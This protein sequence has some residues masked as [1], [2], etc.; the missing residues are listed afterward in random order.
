VE[1]EPVKARWL[2][3]LHTSDLRALE[4]GRDGFTSPMRG[5]GR[6]AE[7]AADYVVCFDDG[8]EVRLPVRRR[9]QIGAFQRGWGENCF[10]AVAHHKPY[11]MRASHEQVNPNWGWSQTRN[12]AADG[13][14]WVNW[15]W[16]WENGYPDKAIT[17]L[18]F[19]PVSGLVVVS[20]ITAG[21][22]AALPLRWEPRRK[23]LLILPEGID[24]Q[25][26][27]DE[28]GVLQQIQLDL[29]QVIS[30]T[31]RLVYPNEAWQDSYNNQLP[32]IT[33]GE[34]IIEYTAHPEACFHLPDGI[35][36]P[37][38]KVEGG[39]EEVPVQP[40]LPATQSVRLR[41][42]ERGSGKPVAVKLHLHG[43]K[44]EY[45]APIDRHRILNPAW[46]ED[47]SVDF[48]HL[49]WSKVD[50]VHACTYIAGETALSC[51]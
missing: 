33:A 28:E 20:A 24:F 1:I 21:D 34:V 10:E 16:A 27:L 25:P 2:V 23:A 14:E 17:G 22:V 13:G 31:P 6:L 41:V 12:S 40:I 44:G 11:A 30:A 9:H 5:R 4:T 7:H 37:L 29:G 39:Q 46:F 49:D 19:E 47:Y 45:L 36:I 50:Q 35:V 18:R 51:R 43:E 42:I 8:S 38:A 26:E 3:F 15:L 32:E 48:A